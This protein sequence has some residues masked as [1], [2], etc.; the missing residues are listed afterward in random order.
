[1]WKWILAKVVEWAV[2]NLTEEFIKEWADKLKNIVIPWLRLKKDELMV[3][4]RA[5]A[6]D[7]TTPLDDLAV[8]AAD[9]F[10]EALLPDNP[11][12]V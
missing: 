4:L 10:L 9:K 7:T 2:S 11:E 12:T 1:M 8:E 3:E 5:K 6:A